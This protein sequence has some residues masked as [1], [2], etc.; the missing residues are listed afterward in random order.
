MK[1]LSRIFSRLRSKTG[2]KSDKQFLDIQ[3]IL[4]KRTTINSSQKTVN[5]KST[6]KK[7]KKN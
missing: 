2:Q 4:N 3:I 1:T 6:S 7:G 5:K